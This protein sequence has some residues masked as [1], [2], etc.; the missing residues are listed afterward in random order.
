MCSVGVCES[1]GSRVTLGRKEQKPIVRMRATFRT[2]LK[3]PS[4]TESPLGFSSLSDCLSKD[5]QQKL[6]TGKY[7]LSE[8]TSYYYSS[9]WTCTT[10]H[11]KRGL[12]TWLHDKGGIDV[13]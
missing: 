13:A 2:C 5:H 8:D 9:T 11:G 7:S 10:R 1:K 4:C 12:V 3:V 6:L